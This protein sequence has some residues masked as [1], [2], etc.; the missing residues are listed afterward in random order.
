MRF[1]KLIKYFKLNFPD[2]MLFIETFL[3]LLF[4]KVILLLVPLR[5]LTRHFGTNNKTSPS[6]TIKEM[7][8]ALRIRL[9]MS[10]VSA[11]VLW[12]SVCLDQALAT[13]LL[14]AR[15]KIPHCLFFGVK[16][17]DTADKIIAHAWV[18]CG[19]TIL[20]GGGRSRHYIAVAG[21]SKIFNDKAAL[22]SNPQ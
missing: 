7:Q 10:G 12:K 1:K 14:L 15:R 21:Y 22:Q 3:L 5:K 19:D 4:V 9:S 6:L 13:T 16:K 2:K 17:N 20:I 8:E 11:N 18:T